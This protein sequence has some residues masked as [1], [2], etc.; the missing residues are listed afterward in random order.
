[1]AAKKKEPPAPAAEKTS[2]PPHKPAG[3]TDN[4][5]PTKTLAQLWEGTA[6]AESL[7]QYDKMK[8]L[9]TGPSGG[10]KTTMAAKLAERL[11]Y[12][13]TELQGVVRIKRNNPKARIH[14]ITSAKDL[15][16]FMRM[17]RDPDLPKHVDG[18]VLDSLNDV[19]RIVKA[20]YIEAQNKGKRE[21]GEKPRE[22]ADVGTWGLI[23][24]RTAWVARQVRDIPVHVMVLCVDKEE[25][26]EGEG[27]VHR[28]AVN[29]K[30]LPNELAQYFNLVGFIHKVERS[31]GVRHEV[32]FNGSDNF[33]TK[34][35]P[36]LD[37]IEPPEPGIWLH[38]VWGR[39]IAPEV[40]FRTAAWAAKAMN[41]EDAPQGEQEPAA[42]AGNTSAATQEEDPFPT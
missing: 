27:R 3:A 4:N 23:I 8:S 17:I 25:Y 34:G 36:E 22:G 21:S 24:E 20:T 7:V 30:S 19:Q 16:E 41:P 38:K 32:L 9:V 13:V 37:D 28:P 12:G 10:G 2:T 35:M 31:N 33:L 18:V 26:V 5:A 1:M 39:P 40:A 42:P 11:L 15:N 29:G 6:E 14:T